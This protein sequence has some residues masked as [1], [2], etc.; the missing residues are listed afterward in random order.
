MKTP[1]LAL[2]ALSVSLLLVGTTCLA[3]AQS[4][5]TFDVPGAV[6]TFPRAANATGR[7]AGEYLDSSNVRH[8][9]VRGPLGAITSFDSPSADSSSTYVVGINV[10]GDVIGIAGRVLNARLTSRGFIRRGDG[11]ITEFDVAS[12]T[13]YTQPWAIN[14]EGTVAGVYVDSNYQSHG[15]VRSRWGAI[16][17]F[18]VP[19]LFVNVV[20]VGPRGEVIG[21]YIES[22]GRGH[23]FLREP[24]GTF[25]SFEAPGSSQATGGIGCGKCSGSRVTAANAFDQVVGMFGDATGDRHQFRGSA[26][27]TLTP[28]DLPDAVPDFDFVVS[29][30]INLEGDIAG[31]RVDE[32][33]V[34]HGFLMLR[35][36]TFDVFE[37]PGGA[38]T[39]VALGAGR[40]V[41][42]YYQD[43]AGQSHGFI[44]TPSAACAH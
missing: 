22:N 20:T 26:Y 19:G 16:T 42:G 30:A 4:I 25:L 12:D 7:I 23:G 37:I 29:A 9:F 27:G 40:S 31:Y 10:V 8:A 35:D 2:Q 24:N 14:A 13:I 3:H 1:L 21:N 11:V 5:V 18:E 44:R 36:G 41:I 28:F 15:F 32:S 39:V 38:L 17:S 6:G 33:D 43:G 34:T